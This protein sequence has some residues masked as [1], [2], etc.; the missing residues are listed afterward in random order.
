MRTDGA[1]WRGSVGDRAYGVGV[2]FRMTVYDQDVRV[3]VSLDPIDVVVE[4]ML[5]D[6]EQIK[7]I[8]AVLMA[9]LQTCFD[10][11]G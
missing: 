6:A 8:K 5:K 10:G 4:R 3:R 9:E 1:M 7:L 2:A 11:S